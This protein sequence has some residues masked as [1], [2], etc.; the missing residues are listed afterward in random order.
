MCKT[1]RKCYHSL[2]VIGK[3]NCSKVLLKVLLKESDETLTKALT[4]L[5][6]N[7]A[8]EDG[9][10][11]LTN[12]EKRFVSQNKSAIE[13]LANKSI[14]RSVKNNLLCKLGPTFCRQTIPPVLKTVDCPRAFTNNKWGGAAGGG[15]EF[16]DLNG[17]RR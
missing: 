6:H 5:Y 14:K 15:D 8:K 11:T 12:K 17:D 7:L 9:P 10:V 13:T 1:I 4:E 2:A 16:S 3:H